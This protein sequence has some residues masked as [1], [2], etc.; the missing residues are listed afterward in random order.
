MPGREPHLGQMF[1]KAGYKTAIFGKSQPLSTQLVNLDQTPEEKR[2]VE[3]KRVEWA[4]ANFRNPEAPG[5]SGRYPGDEI[6]Q[7]WELGNYTI[8]QSE[9]ESFDY[10]YSFTVGNPC[11]K[12]NGYFENGLQTSEFTKWGIQRFYP[13]GSNDSGG[14]YVAAPWFEK[15]TFGQVITGNYPRSMVAQAD[16][17]SRTQDEVISKKVFSFIRDQKPSEQPFFAYWGLRAGHRPF[18]SPER[19]RNTTEAG[20]LGEMIAEADDYVGELFKTLEESGKANNTLI[21]FL[22]DNGADNSNKINN[23]LYGHIQNAIDLNGE[24]KVL[25]GMKNSNYEGGHRLPFMWWY[26]KQF[27]PKTV[28]DK[29][30]S[31]VDIYRTLSDIIGYTPP[32]NEAPDSR[33]LH[34]ILKSESDEIEGHN[35]IL[36][37][38]PKG[39]T[40]AFRHNKWKLIPEIKEFYDVERD[41][42]E[43]NNLWNVDWAQKMIVDFNNW[44]TEILTRIERREINQNFGQKKTC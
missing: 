17:D 3:R 13:E 22:S 24:R 29:P 44:L 10:D 19:Y 32:C 1:S 11:C 25:R 23:R 38:S 27:Q 7:F 16:Y 21:L 39:G 40:V 20:I 2:E 33:S 37:H 5:L 9:V 12:P 18:N 36:T 28:Q 4:K 43:K 34:S 15:E 41:P 30:V 8:K 35:W 26:P 14:A 42:E 31:Y 6:N